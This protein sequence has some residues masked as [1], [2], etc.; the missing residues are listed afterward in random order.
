MSEPTSTFREPVKQEAPAQPVKDQP[1]ADVGSPVE[2][3]VPELLA[4]YSDDQGKP[5]IAEYL[6]VDNIWDQ[7]KTLENELNTIEGF[8][9]DQIKKGKLDNS[10]KAGNKFLQALEKKAET[11]PYEGTNKR[12]SKILAYIEFQRVV[13][14]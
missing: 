11:N 12:I 10:T 14:G 4:T 1:I 8:L 6:G 7:D 5:Y 13:H 2:T 3:K 9:K